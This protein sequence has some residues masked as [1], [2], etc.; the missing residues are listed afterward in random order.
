MVQRKLIIVPSNIIQGLISALH[1]QLDHPSSHQLQQMFDRFFFA[2]NSASV[3]RSVTDQCALCNSLKHIPKEIF[4]QTSTTSLLCPG[5][6]FSTDV[7][8]R[9]KQKVLETRDVFSSYTTAII[10]PDET[11]DTLRSTIITST[12]LLCMPASTVRV[13]GATG[14]L[15]LKNDV[16]L[17]KNGIV[18]DFGLVKNKNKNPVVDKCIQELE[19]ELILI[20][21]DGR[22]LTQSAL[23]TSLNN[24]NLRICSQGLSAKEIVL[25]RDQQSGTQLD[26]NDKQIAKQQESNRN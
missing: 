1:L 2:L 16:K 9:T 7:L 25:Q 3:I 14:F 13:D 5:K 20:E 11:A 15:T 4:E 23:D 12:N 8:C 19:Q 24:L 6:Q 10:I 22:I 26:I 17:M 18:L 21:S